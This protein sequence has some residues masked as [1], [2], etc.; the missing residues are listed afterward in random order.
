MT[1]RSPPLSRRQLLARTGS[2]GLLLGARDLAFGATI[3]GVR[4]WPAADYSRV[5]IESDVPLAARHFLT[6]DPPRLV[7]DIDQLELSAALRELVGKVKSDDPFI[8]GVRAGQNQPRVVRL[9]VDLKQAVAPQQFTLAPVAAYRHRLVFDL[10][11]THARDPL[12]D[13]IR[14]RNKAEALAA[15][16]VQDALGDFIG[17]I[18]RPRGT[19]PAASPGEHTS[20]QTGIT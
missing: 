13:L 6:D 16:G 14:D 18:E 17:K 20:Y 3:V 11:P 1:R 19:L 15:R 2:F 5:T 4:V 9:V 7:V 12:L 10:F 8:A